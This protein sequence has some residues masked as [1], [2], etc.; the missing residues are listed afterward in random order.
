MMIRIRPMLLLVFVVLVTAACSPETENQ[1]KESVELTISAASSLQDA[2]RKI[3]TEFEHDYPYI[4]IQYNFASSG[5]LQQQISQGAPVDVFLS[6]AAETFDPLVEEGLIDSDQSVDLL[7][8]EIVLI[9]PK[10]AQ[11]KF[12]S[13][14]EVVHAERI[15]IGTPDSVPAGIYGKE[16]LESVSVW[17][18]VEGSLIFA[19]DVR[20]VLTYVET[21]NVD[22]GIV[23]KTDALRSDKVEVAAEAAEQDHSPI[24]YP[25]GVV[26]SGNHPE[27]A[28]LFYHYIQND[29][30]MKMF[31]EYGF[32]DLSE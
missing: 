13:F 31:K 1:E 3:K 12:A 24:V 22:A 25:A 14:E 2:L 17:N 20:Q 32:K 26:S 4:T 18:Q 8:N 9:V 5:T 30:S 10:G 23:Y 11:G 6:A 16:V 7:G 19:K 21:N 29:Q 28:A 27:E 15:A